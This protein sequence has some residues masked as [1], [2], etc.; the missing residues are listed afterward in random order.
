MAGT[1]RTWAAAAAA[2]FMVVVCYAYI[3]GGGNGEASF[4]ASKSDM[5]SKNEVAVKAAADIVKVL[6]EGKEDDSSVKSVIQYSKTHHGLDSGAAELRKQLGTLHGLAARKKAMNSVISS[7]LDI[8][9]AKKGQI[10]LAKKEALAIEK[11]LDQS[12]KDEDEAKSIE[13]RAKSSAGSQNWNEFWGSKHSLVSRLAS[14]MDSKKAKETSKHTT[15]S[16]A[17]KSKRAAQKPKEN[18]PS[19]VEK[20]WNLLKGTRTQ[21]AARKSPKSAKSADASTKSS[22]L[23]LKY[24]QTHQS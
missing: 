16:S 23:A 2:C 4:L 1:G 14:E 17:E 6:N 13:S 10:K 24:F 15:W 21:K 3:G 7:A 19:E 8:N 11:I 5:K 12:S 9:K 18:V 20:M 22:Q